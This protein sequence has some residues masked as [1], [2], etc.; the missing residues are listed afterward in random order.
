M[1]QCWSWEVS[2]GASGAVASKLSSG[3]LSA[4]QEV[5]RG[6][7]WPSCENVP[8]YGLSPLTSAG[9]VPLLSVLYI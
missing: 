1:T 9:T 4:S 3:E 7:P 5:P 6:L 2:E 8:N